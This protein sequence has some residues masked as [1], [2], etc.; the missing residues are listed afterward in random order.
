[1]TALPAGVATTRLLPDNQGLAHWDTVITSAALKDELLAHVLLGL[2]HGPALATL[3][4]AMQ[5]LAM[6]SGPPGTGK[7]TLA[8]GVAEAAADALHH[9]GRIL[10]VELDPHA[11]PSEML[12]ESQRNVARLLGSIIP[13]LAQC[14]PYVIALVDEVESFAVRRS[15]A[16]FEANPVDV[17][18]A[19]DAVLVGLDHLAARCPNVF[20][21]STTNFPV[22]VDE[23]FTSRADL[24][25]HLDLPDEDTA[26]LILG[27][28]LRDL[29][30][31]WPAL[32][33]L[34]ADT[35]LHR[36]V[37][38]LCVGWDGRRLRRL[39]LQA[40]GSRPDLALHPETLTADDLA[41]VVGAPTIGDDARMATTQ[42]AGHGVEHRHDPALTDRAHHHDSTRQTH[43]HEF[44][45]S[46]APQTYEHSDV[47]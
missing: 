20:V 40:L 12:G 36:T 7:T 28:A 17:H 29:A 27:A 26:A 32:A 35:N 30:E 24:I 16:S 14:H 34:A 2:V 33:T 22:A 39:P 43:P 9:H 3:P 37:A 31:R 44:L 42:D 1:V 46:T 19:S 23:A 10:L 4:G 6:L 15:A 41:R 25:L 38:G 8:R 47:P 13:E 18:R 21:L 45:P 5:R 11:L